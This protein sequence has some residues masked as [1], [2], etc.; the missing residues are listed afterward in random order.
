MS[1]NWAHYTSSVSTLRNQGKYVHGWNGAIRNKGE[2]Q[3]R[4]YDRSDQ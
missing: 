1:R 3:R 4:F 2:T